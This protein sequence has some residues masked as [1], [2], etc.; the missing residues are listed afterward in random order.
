MKKQIEDFIEEEDLDFLMTLKNK[1]SNLNKINKNNK[2]KKE[3]LFYKK[4]YKNE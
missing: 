4:K 1:S 2:N 3:N